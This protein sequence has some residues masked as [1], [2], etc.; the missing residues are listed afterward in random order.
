MYMSVCSIF[1]PS[2]FF[3]IRKKRIRGGST[4]AE[5]N[6]GQRDPTIVSLPRLARHDTIDSGQTTHTV[7]IE[8]AGSQAGRESRKER[9][10]MDGGRE[11]RREGE[12]GEGGSNGRA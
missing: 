8:L 11:G 12:S 6:S 3:T 4:Y 9:G 5:C 10:R 7:Y 2:D 1:R